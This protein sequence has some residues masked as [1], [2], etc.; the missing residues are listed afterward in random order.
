MVSLQSLPMHL[1]IPMRRG[2]LLSDVL[3]LVVGKNFTTSATTWIP[4]CG[5]AVMSSVKSISPSLILRAAIAN[6]RTT[7][8]I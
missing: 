6:F 1:K 8:L 7:N 2:P 5:H 4:T 3:F